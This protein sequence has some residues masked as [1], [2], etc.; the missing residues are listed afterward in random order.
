[1][2]KFHVTADILFGLIKLKLSD[3]RAINKTAWFSR[4]VK[5]NP[6][7]SFFKPINCARSLI[8]SVE[9]IY[10]FAVNVNLS[11]TYVFGSVEILSVLIYPFFQLVKW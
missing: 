8:T 6:L 10:G 4:E 1:M 9:H 5:L 2:Y 3:V 11:P 7:F